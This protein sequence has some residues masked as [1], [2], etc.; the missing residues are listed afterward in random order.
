MF[1]KRNVEQRLEYIE[2]K[3]I[4]ANEAHNLSQQDVLVKPNR[5]EKAALKPQLDLKAYAEDLNVP[6]ELIERWI[7]ANI[8]FPNEI[9][10]AEQIIRIMRQND[11]GRLN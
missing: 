10:V 5:L 6:K 4:E 9:K 1:A 8:L 11:Q 3:A 7:S 2:Q